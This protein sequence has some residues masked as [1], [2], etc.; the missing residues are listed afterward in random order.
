MKTYEYSARTSEGAVQR[1][2]MEAKN[3]TQVVET[4]QSKGLIVVKVEEKVALSAALSEVNIGG[5]PMD[6]KVVFMRQFATMTSSGLPITQTLEILA[7]QASNPQFKKVL[8]DVLSEVEGGKSLAKSFGKH[9]GIF[10]DVVL[11]LIKAGEDSGN[12][13]QIFLRLAEELEKQR[14][15]QGKIKSA[16]IYPAIILVTIVAVVVLVMLFMIPAVRDIYTEFG[17]EI[18]AVTKF[19]IALSDFTVSYWWIVLILVL[20]L[21]MGVKYYIDTPGGRRVVDNLK[22]TM[23]VFGPLFKKIE[24]AQMT[25]TLYLLVSG[26]IPILESLD[27]VAE[28]LGNVWY[29]DAIDNAAREIEKGS[30]LSLPLSREEKIPLI[31]SQ[32]IAVGEETGR[33]DEILKKMAE[34]YSAEVDLMTNN[35]ATLIEPIML[36]VMGVVVGFIAVAVYMPLFSLAQVIE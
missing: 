9:P 30:T 28:S 25:Q 17:G 7:S 32:M 24:L 18:P 34:Y 36:I 15:F 19:L 23:P 6:D 21:V 26:G 33:L 2:E 12:L 3:R 16:M 31:V 11:N 10:S 27:L 4:L 29:Q 1:G 22:L 14:D 35:I 13:E 8:K 20:S 5:V